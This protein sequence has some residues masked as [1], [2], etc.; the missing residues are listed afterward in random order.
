MINVLVDGGVRSRFAPAFE[1]AILASAS[2]HSPGQSISLRSDPLSSFVGAKAV[3]VSQ[4]S[5][6]FF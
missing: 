6:E 1:V 2:A 4:C 5:L 3:D